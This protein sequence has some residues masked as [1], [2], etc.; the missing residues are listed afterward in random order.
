LDPVAEDLIVRKTL[1]FQRAEECFYRRIIIAIS[2]PTHAEIGPNNTQRFAHS[3]A[4]ILA[5]SIGV[6]VQALIRPAQNQ[7]IPECRKNQFRLQAL[8]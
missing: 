7:G 1:C 8:T 2:Y 6:K 5:A 4:A 3:F